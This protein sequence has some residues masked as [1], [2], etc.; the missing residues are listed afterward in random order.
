MTDFAAKCSI[1]IASQPGLNSRY[2]VPPSWYRTAICNTN[3]CMCTVRELHVR[4]S[5]QNDTTFRVLI[6]WHASI[7]VIVI[8][9]VSAGVYTTTPRAVGT[10]RLRYMMR[11]AD[12]DAVQLEPSVSYVSPT[13]TVAAVAAAAAAVG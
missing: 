11:Q 8:H 12:V 7:L 2:L 10:V 13:V 9:V 4:T 1:L 3:K 5:L 6:Y